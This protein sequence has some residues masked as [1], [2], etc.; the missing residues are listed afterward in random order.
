VFGCVF[1]ACRR[2]Q[3]FVE[4]LLAAPVDVVCLRRREILDRLALRIADMEH[5]P[6]TPGRPALVQAL[7]RLAD[8]DGLW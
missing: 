5:D 4:G 6:T 3:S 2:P 1:V 7:N 8:M